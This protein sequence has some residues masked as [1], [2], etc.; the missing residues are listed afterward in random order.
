MERTVRVRD[1][2]LLQI[3]RLPR[4]LGVA[5]RLERSRVDVDVDVDSPTD[6]SPL[7]LVTTTERRVHAVRAVQVEPAHA[8]DSPARRRERRQRD[9]DLRTNRR[10]LCRHE[11][12]ELLLERRHELVDQHEAL[13]ELHRGRTVSH[14]FHERRDVRENLL[15]KHGVILIAGTI[16]KRNLPER[17]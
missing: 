3:P 11:R 2:E 10:Q 7:A 1:E 16:L 5:T 12:R 17:R 14:V 13:A 8:V 4:L 6:T 9:R 15:T